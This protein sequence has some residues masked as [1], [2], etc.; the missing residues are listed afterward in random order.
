MFAIWD[1]LGNG[2]ERWRPVVA[3]MRPGAR[4]G[5]GP[6]ENS[7]H[8]VYII[9]PWIG[10]RAQSRIGRY[11]RQVS[12]DGERQAAGSQEKGPPAARKKA[13]RRAGERATGGQVNRPLAGR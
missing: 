9:L 12:R 4:Q 7:K 10:L 8:K 1:L 13:R 6:Q 2:V 5:A 3:I 11:A